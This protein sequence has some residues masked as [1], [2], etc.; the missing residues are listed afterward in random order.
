MSLLP[1]L[2]GSASVVVALAAAASP[3]QAASTVTFPAGETPVTTVQITD[4]GPASPTVHLVVTAADPADL[5][6]THVFLGNDY[7]I[8]YSAVSADG[9]RDARYADGADDEV[10]T[11][12]CLVY[13]GSELVADT[14][15][16]V[17]GASYSADLP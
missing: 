3:A 17:S 4:P 11:A 6:A 15:V 1:R 5:A 8:P 12:D 10:S 2:L 13:D 7:S 16:T 9:V 14:P